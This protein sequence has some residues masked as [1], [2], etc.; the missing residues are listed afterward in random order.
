MTVVGA[1]AAAPSFCVL[2]DAVVSSAISGERLSEYML[3]AAIT[4]M[5]VST[6]P[7]YLIIGIKCGFSCTVTYFS[8]ISTE[9]TAEF[10][11]LS[12]R[13]SCAVLL[14]KLSE[15]FMLFTAC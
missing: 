6:M 3:I 12:S 8:D 2:P 11:S 13:I 1:G 7:P 14:L 4:A 15:I 9:F 10:L 5:A